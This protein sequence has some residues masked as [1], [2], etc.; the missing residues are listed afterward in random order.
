MRYHPRVRF[1][2][3]LLLAAWALLSAAGCSCILDFD[4]FNDA[5]GAGDGGGPDGGALLLQVVCGA[6]AGGGC[7]LEEGIGTGVR[8]VPAAL[9]ASAPVFDATTTVAA[10][11]GASVI[12][13]GVR[14]P[15]GGPAALVG[16]TL[17]APVDESIDA[18]EVLVPLTVT[19]NGTNLG[20]DV[21]V[22]VRHHP[23]L[24]VTA[25]SAATG[26]AYA[27]S[28]VVVSAD[29]RATGP[30]PL[31]VKV[32][33]D[34]R[35]M[36]G[37]TFHVDG[38]LMPS[39][40]GPGGPGA[41][42]GVGGPGGGPM[43]A[44]ASGSGAGPGLGG[45]G[46]IVGGP[47]ATGGG[48]AG[49]GVSGQ[50]A[51]AG[52]GTGGGA[53]GD[54]LLATFPASE[55]AGSGGGGGGGG[56]VSG[57]L[58]GAGGEGGG[59]LRLDVEGA[60]VFDAGARVSANGS[61][62]GAGTGA[63]GT[64]AGGGGGSGGG[65]WIAAAEGLVGAS[66]SVEATGGPGAGGALPG[67]T[68]GSGYVRLDAPGAIVPLVLP[69]PLYYGVKWD[70]V[71]EE[72]VGAADVSG[73]VWGNPNLAVEVQLIDATGASAIVITTALDAGGQAVVPATLAP[74]WNLLRA[75]SPDCVAPS[76]V[77]DITVVYVP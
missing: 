24:I 58:G 41:A 40:G 23:E 62:G 35:L 10:P 74:G 33:G 19:V 70:W 42:G 7:A 37:A 57:D 76:S 21:A 51:P 38:V 46:G 77:D 22:L 26:G 73:T 49:H 9:V 56:T 16:L 4:R 8:A 59:A 65:V 54:A 11:P 71:L 14:P 50:S 6:G 28:S 34:V 3:A 13:T 72:T 64:A 44:G 67:G 25:D 43:A 53:Y 1:A 75:C 63:G 17:V 68:G 2:G 30:E 27:F 36:A 32:W 20:A 69:A 18:G 45:A 39:G 5:S 55:V 29:Y 48:G 66:G 61:A 15:T 31:D 52:P 60:V 12:V 47:A